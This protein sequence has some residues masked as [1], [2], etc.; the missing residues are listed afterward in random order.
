MLFD[1]PGTDH[2][3]ALKFR[4]LRH[5]GITYLLLAGWHYED[6]AQR[7]GNTPEVIRHHYRGV[8]EQ[9]GPATRQPEGAGQGDA[10]DGSDLVSLGAALS[11][12]SEADACTL[13]EGHLEGQSD[14]TAVTLAKAIS[15]V[16][17]GRLERALL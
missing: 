7:V 10:V 8:I 4:H 2:L 6:V 3:S 16:A 1:Q 13:I 15:A 11:E 12:L 5:S 14:S 17:R 9:A